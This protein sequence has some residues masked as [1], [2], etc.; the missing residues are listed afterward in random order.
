MLI[1]T[2]FAPVMHIYYILYIYMRIYIVLINTFFLCQFIYLSGQAYIYCVCVYIYIY[3]YV[4]IY[5]H[6]MCVYTYIYTHM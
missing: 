4:Y 6:Y 5:T 3:M 2:F 1:N